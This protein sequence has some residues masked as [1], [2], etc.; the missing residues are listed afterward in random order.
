[1]HTKVMAILNFAMSILTFLP[2]NT[3]NGLL[4]ILKWK[5]CVRVAIHP[6]ISNI[7]LQNTKE[8]CCFFLPFFFPLLKKKTHFALALLQTGCYLF[9]FWCDCPLDFWLG[10]WISC[11]NWSIFS[12]FFFGRFNDAIVT[13]QLAKFSI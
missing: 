13:A 9:Q 1:M 4:D 12:E 3:Q 2:R 8:T 11:L 7:C 10:H 6:T 5:I